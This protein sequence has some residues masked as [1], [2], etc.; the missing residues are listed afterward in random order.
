MRRTRSG[1][2]GC[3]LAIGIGLVLAVAPPA[4]AKKFQMSGTWIMRKGEFF[5][6]FQ[7][8]S[9]AVQSQNFV[10]MGNLTEAIMTPT[11]GLEVPGQL[12]QDV[13]GVTATG[14]APQTLRIPKHRFVKDFGIAQPL[15]GTMVVQITTMIGIDAPADT[16]TLRAGGA[17]GALT[18]CPGNPACV[19]TGLPALGR[20]VYVPTGA[21]RFGGTMQMGLW[22]GGV[23]SVKSQL[24]PGLIAHIP[25]QGSGTIARRLAVGGMQLGSNTPATEMVTLAPGVLTLPGMFPASG[26]L[27]TSPGPIIMTPHGHLNAQNATSSIGGMGGSITTRWG[28]LTHGGTEPTITTHWGFGHTTG[29]VIVQQNTGTGGASFFT[30]MGSDMRTPQ[31]GGNISTVAGGLARRT[32]PVGATYTAQWDKV[33]LVLG[34]P[35]PSISPTGVAAAGALMLLAVGYSLRRRLR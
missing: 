21:L 4:P 14:V 18:W 11:G 27:I 13:G 8:A 17:P 24:I 19:A 15:V 3:V 12:L 5:L 23:V 32:N 31:G 20:V 7:F 28:Q 9:R 2:R 25:F 29:T 22:G 6:P 30:V 33:S 26:D 1:Q 34:P 16:A 10:S 35:V